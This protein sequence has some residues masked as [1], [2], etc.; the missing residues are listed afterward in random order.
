MSDELENLKARTSVMELMREAQTA[1]TPPVVPLKEDAYAAM[2]KAHRYSE[3]L[4]KLLTA[5]LGNE[6]AEALL[7]AMLDQE[8]VGAPGHWTCDGNGGHR[9]D[10]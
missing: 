8:V 3:T 2:E 7:K 5:E 1:C 6:Q 9:R 10:R 4:D